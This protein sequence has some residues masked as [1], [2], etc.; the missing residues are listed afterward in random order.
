MVNGSLIVSGE[1]ARSPFAKLT[2][3]TD[4]NR[5]ADPAGG[6]AGTPGAR[7][8]AAPA[9]WDGAR[10]GEAI[11]LSPQSWERT[12]KPG[13]DP[14]SRSSLGRA[15]VAAIALAVV[16]PLGV[17]AYVAI[18][19]RQQ[20]ALIAEHRNENANLARTLSTLSARLD[21]LETVKGRDDLAELRRSVS[22]IKTAAATSRELGSAIADLSTRVEKL[23]REGDAKIGKLGER[24]DRDINT[25]AAE[26]SARL[27]KLERTAPAAAATAGAP[28]AAPKL[29][30]GVAMEPTGSIGR[31]PPVLRG[32]VVLGVQDD[33]ALI[34]GRYGERPVRA[35]DY[36]PGAGRVERVQ[37]QGSAW[38]V[39]T[40]KGLIPSAYP[41]S[42]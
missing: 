11:L 34:D 30:S 3:M 16:T 13:P 39:V 19:G 27:E 37:R 9:R 15:A 12:Q 1:N 36:L 35:G 40:D 32:Y 8:L 7:R 42:D 2:P 21:A 33:V 23:D 41:E 28:S 20:S 4:D 17:A 31:Q 10:A 38:V 14:S 6:P 26:V 29:G 22:E 5:N 25:R 18:D 24:V